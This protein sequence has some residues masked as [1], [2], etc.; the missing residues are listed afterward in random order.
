MQKLTKEQAAIIRAY[1]GYLIGDFS[2]MHSA[3]EK[4]LGRPVFIHG[5]ATERMAEEIREAFK[6]DFIALCPDSVDN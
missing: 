1:T 6:E 3:I 5:L 4:K 2:D